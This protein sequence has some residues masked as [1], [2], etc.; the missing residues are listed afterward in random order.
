MKNWGGSVCLFVCLICNE[1]EQQVS[2]LKVQL[3][4]R[5]EKSFGF[6]KLLETVKLRELT[7]F[8]LHMQLIC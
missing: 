3:I 5:N 8:A 2:D 6:K 4:L 7:R 1:C